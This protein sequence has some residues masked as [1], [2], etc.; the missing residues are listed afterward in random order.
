LNN[1]AGNL[2]KGIDLTFDLQTQEDYSSGERSEL[3]TL[4]VGA[5]KTLFNDRLTVAIG[6]NIGIAGANASNA[7][8][9]IGDV[10][11]D[12]ALSRD[13]RY[14]MRAY[15]RNQTDA[16]LEGQIIETGLSF[17]LVMDY[18][19]FREIFQKAK[20]EQEAKKIK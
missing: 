20:K 3:T 7:S 10:S 2:I 19:K 6:S 11:V 4:N 16:V 1:L 9:L 8:A 17:I 5:S 18:D 14:K 15:Q 12:Y 13:G